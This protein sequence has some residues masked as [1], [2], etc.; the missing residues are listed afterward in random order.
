MSILN[1]EMGYA[2]VTGQEPSPR[3]VKSKAAEKPFDF[4]FDLN[5]LFSLQFDQL[6]QAI[7]YLA[8]RQGEQ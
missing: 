2:D 4:P 5:N 7:E 6:K 1:S 8:R 3:T